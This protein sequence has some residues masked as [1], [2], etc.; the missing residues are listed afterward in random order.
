MA[1]LISGGGTTMAEIIKACKSGEIPNMD[2]ACVVSSNPE[3]GGIEKA[4]ALGIEDI[5]VVNPRDFKEGGR[6]NEEQFGKVLFNELAMRN[7]TVVTQNGWLPHTPDLMREK[8]EGFIFNQHPGPVPEFGGKDMWGK[9]VHAALLGYRR[10][11]SG[12]W[13]REES[14]TEV[15]AQRVDKDHDQGAVVKKVRV[16]ILP[17]DTP[18]DLQKRAL[19]VE[20]RVQ[21]ELLKDVAGGSVKEVG[22]RPPIVTTPAEELVWKLSRKMAVLLYPKG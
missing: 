11:T 13:R 9:R 2:I 8:Y 6:V 10:W 16:V 17:G 20:H 15:I 22:L 3:A 7:V 18:E 14:W 1:T 4:R 12:D 19:P 5:M 21:I